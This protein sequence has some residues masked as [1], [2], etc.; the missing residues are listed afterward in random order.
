MGTRGLVSIDLNKCT[1]CGKCPD[2]CPDDALEMIE[3][4]AYWKKTIEDPCVLCE[5]CVCECEP[6]AISVDIYE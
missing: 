1:G 4:K 6:Q 5:T 3:N 2:I